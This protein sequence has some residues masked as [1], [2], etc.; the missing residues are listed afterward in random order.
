MEELVLSSEVL[1]KGPAHN[2][3]QVAL[4][5]DRIPRLLGMLPKDRVPGNFRTTVSYAFDAAGGRWVL[6]QDLRRDQLLAE[7][8]GWLLSRHL[9]VPTPDAGVVGTGDQMAWASRFVD[10]ALQ[11]SP[12]RANV[13]SNVDGL[14]A[15]IAFDALIANPDRHSENI[16][17]VPQES[18]DQ[19][20]VHSIDLEGAWAGDPAIIDGAGLDVPEVSLTQPAYIPVDLIDSSARELAARAERL[21][22]ATLAVYVKEACA[23]AGEPDHQILQRALQRRLS[24]ATQLVRDYLKAIEALQT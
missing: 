14:G 12:T 5:H 20:F 4:V 17:C 23:L 19:V 11:W 1:K 7:A 13:V 2:P 22:N 24:A 21:D 15:M 6:K 8:L 18:A 3:A 16:L 10:D 9:G